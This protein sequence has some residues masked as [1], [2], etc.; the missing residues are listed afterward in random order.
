MQHTIQHQNQ[1]LMAQAA[2]LE[3]LKKQQLADTVTLTS[4]FRS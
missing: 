3:D 1:F 2:V 4:F